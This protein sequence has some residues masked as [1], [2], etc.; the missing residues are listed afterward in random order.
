MEGY[1]TLPTAANIKQCR[2]VEKN[3]HFKII[4]IQNT[5]SEAVVQKFLFTSSK[6]TSKP[7]HQVPKSPAQKEGPESASTTS[8]STQNLCPENS[9]LDPNRATGQD[10]GCSVKPTCCAHAFCLVHKIC[11]TAKLRT[12]KKNLIL[13]IKILILKQQGSSLKDYAIKLL[14]NVNNV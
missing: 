4:H 7:V 8:L 14:Q 5:R 12:Q 6:A 3:K 1:F 9:L 2:V 13:E 11:I 10:R